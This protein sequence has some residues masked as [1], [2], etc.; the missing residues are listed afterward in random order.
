MAQ[1]VLCLAAGGVRAEN[2]DESYQRASV[3]VQKTRK[4]LAV[5]REKSLAPAKSAEIFQRQS[6]VLTGLVNDALVEAQRKALVACYASGYEQC[7][8]MSSYTDKEFG[9]TVGHAVVQGLGTKAGVSF[10]GQSN[11]HTGRVMDDALAEAQGKALAG[12]YAA[13]YKQ[14]LFRWS[15][16]E[17]YGGGHVGHAVV[18]GF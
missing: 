9:G 14:C 2:L 13:G 3:A 6:N 11:I 10:Q 18:Q 4:A 16:T 12:C 15:Y 17:E 1:V 5:S 8:L 7:Q